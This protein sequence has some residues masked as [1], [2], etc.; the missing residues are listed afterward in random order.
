MRASKAH[1]KSSLSSSSCDYYIYRGVATPAR[2][3]ATISWLEPRRG[4]GQ[5]GSTKERRSYHAAGVAK[6]D[7]GARRGGREISNG[8]VLEKEGGFVGRVQSLVS[9]VSSVTSRVASSAATHVFGNVRRWQ[10]TAGTL[11]ARD[12]GVDR[13]HDVDVANRESRRAARRFPRVRAVL[14]WRSIEAHRWYL[15]YAA[16]P[17]ILTTPRCV[18][19]AATSPSSPSSSSSRALSSSP[20]RVTSATGGW[21]IVSSYQ[22]EASCDSSTATPRNLVWT[23][24]VRLLSTSPREHRIRG[25]VSVSTVLSF[26]RLLPFRGDFGRFE[27]LNLRTWNWFPTTKK[28]FSSV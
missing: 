2:V 26:R 12:N 10:P 18:C 22:R 11:S 28:V 24:R 6:R 4:K 20:R 25:R 17:S 14:P 7:G 27:F 13:V 8:R 3:P 1:P 15:G 16:Q 9:S 21:C 23:N 5:G 19:P